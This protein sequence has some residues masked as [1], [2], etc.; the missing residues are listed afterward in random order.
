LLREV[1]ETWDSRD[2]ALNI[3]RDGARRVIAR[4]D[5]GESVSTYGEIR[6]IVRDVQA[7][8][9]VTLAPDE[10][11][12][13]SKWLTHP[14][15]DALYRQQALRW[16]A[17]AAKELGLSLG[18]YGN[19][20]DAHPDFAAYARGPV[21]YGEPLRELTRRAAINLQIVPY[22]CL[23]QRLLDGL[24]AGGF[25]LVRQNPNDVHPQALLNFL[26]QHAGPTA[27]TTASARAAI[28][29][30]LCPEFERL[31]ALAAPGIVS[32]DA[33]DPVTLVRDWADAGNLQVLSDPRAGADAD[34]AA[35]SGATAGAGAG[36][37]VDADTDVGPVAETHDIEPKAASA[38]E[39]RYS[40]VLKNIGIAEADMP[41][42]RGDVSRAQTAANSNVLKN[43]RTA[44]TVLLPRAAGV[45]VLPDL[46]D[47]S[48]DGDGRLRELLARFARDPRARWEIAS[49]QRA[50]VVGRMSYTA[51]M[52]RV[53]RRI[54]ELLSE[55]ARQAAEGAKRCA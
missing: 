41:R 48:F 34:T 37:G 49:R 44:E 45:E 39:H 13:V 38:H 23:H 52:D 5:A 10:T 25:F 15:N 1:G 6:A 55:T 29:A 19:G 7:A 32:T 17:A 20:W 50:A 3:L 12:A 9:G 27:R 16:A 8:Q 24:A 4:Y 47:V 18:L 42:G 22:L 54:A 36:V 28:P 33:E 21:A 14:F 26:E 43:T 53:R 40:I 11:L 30:E 31:L 2:V 46:G 35:G 51:G